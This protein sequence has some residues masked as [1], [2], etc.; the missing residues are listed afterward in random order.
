MLNVDAVRSWAKQTG[1]TLERDLTADPN[2]KK[3][4][5]ERAPRFAESFRGYERPQ[6]FGLVTEDF[7]IESGL[8]TPS[9]K[10]K[11]R[12]AI[13]RFG[14]ALEALYRQPRPQAKRGGASRVVG[15]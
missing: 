3:L 13:A 5:E 14:E 1:L 7:T 12:E 2:V 11:R 15:A 10:L 4:V 6:A 8:L 9:M